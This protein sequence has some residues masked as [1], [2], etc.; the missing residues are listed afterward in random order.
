MHQIRIR[1]INIGGRDQLALIA[2]PCA[3]E[4][5][6]LCLDTAKKIKDMTAKL[7]IPYI[8]KSS[9]D[10]ANRLSIESFRG[11]GVKKGL[12]VLRKVKEMRSRSRAEQE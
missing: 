2:G 9:F 5:E 10:K 8:F 3:I 7:G 4:S 11:P 12:E 6:H 1:D